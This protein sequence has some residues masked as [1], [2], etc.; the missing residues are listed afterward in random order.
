[1]ADVASSSIMALWKLGGFEWDMVH[2]RNFVRQNIRY[3]LMAHRKTFLAADLDDD[4]EFHNLCGSVWPTQEQHVEAQLALRL[5][6]HLEPRE[7]QALL[8]LGDGGSPLDVADELRTDAVGAV[9]LIKR[10]RRKIQ[11]VLS[12][13]RIADCEG[14]FVSH[15]RVA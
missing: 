15:R 4:N 11:E 9:M 2:V 12:T 6:I 14:D 5:L 1:M 13:D 10:A 8:I 7:R 3:A